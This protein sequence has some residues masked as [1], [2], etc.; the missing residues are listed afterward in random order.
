MHG[1][2]GHLYDITMPTSFEMAKKCPLKAN[3]LEGKSHWLLR[4]PQCG[5]ALYYRGKASVEVFK[6]LGMVL[7]T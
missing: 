2:S 6:L 7:E 3:R 1:Y 5:K 4:Q